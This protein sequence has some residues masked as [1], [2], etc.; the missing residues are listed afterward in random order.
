VAKSNRRRKR[1]RAVRQAKAA[2]KQA[3]ARRQQETD[4]AVQE[5]ERRAYTIRD[6]ATPAEEVAN[7]L[8]TRYEDR[9]PVMA[10]LTDGLAE[11]G[12]SPER[13][14]KISEL[15]QA[16][17]AT[18][19]KPPSMAW[20][21]F[22][23]GAA[24]AAGDTDRARRLLDQA[25]DQADDPVSRIR[26]SA[27]LRVHGRAAEAV[28]LLEGIMRE[29]PEAEFAAEQYAVTIEEI[30]ER[31]SADNPP[32]PCPCGSGESGPDCCGSRERAALDRFN[33]RSGLTAFQDAIAAYAPRSAYRKGFQEFVAEW[34]SAT[35]EDNWYSLERA[36]FTAL[37]SELALILA[38]GPDEDPGS[39]P[40]TG[41]DIGDGDGEENVLTA[42]ARDPDVPEELAGQARSWNEHIR[43]G[44]WQIAEPKA[45]PGVWCTEIATGVTRYVAFP[46][47]TI[48]RFPRW[49]VLF[50][51]IVPVD[52]IWRYTGQAFQVSPDEADALADTLTDNTEALLSDLTGQ[53]SKRATRRARRS[54]PFGR[55]KPNGVTVYAA[56]EAL[57]ETA[58]FFGM[59][60][61]SMLLGLVAEVHEH[62]AQPP[63]MANTDGDPI[64]LITAL[65][66]V[67]D[68]EGLPGL[69]ADHADFDQDPTEPTRLTWLGRIMPVNQ[70]DTLLAEVKARVGSGEPG[71]GESLSEVGPER[72]VRG[73][74]QVK[75]GA[76]VAEVNS[77]ERLTRLVDLLRKLGEDPVVTEQIR[78]DPGQDLAWP[79]GPRAFPRGAAPPEEGW[80][81]HWLDEHVPA[82]HG[83]TPRQ[84][85]QSQ[86]RVYL[87]ALLREFEYEADIL[88]AEGKAGIDTAWLR[89]EL[90]MTGDQYEWFM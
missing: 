26:L 41:S 52:G 22:A 90:D 85:A 7:L 88:A 40:G 8:A 72:W 25:F 84:A 38:E 65:I 83:Q 73:L 5:A 4:L 24:R 10:T 29:D 56:E 75:N 82:L 32:D 33:D 3:A 77:E 81:K 20:L 59:V 19:D 57:P 67:R 36:S 35:E 14:V 54:I 64:Q 11:A 74:L 16:V 55:A 9:E 50:G 61:V 68:P 48:R 1:D 39:D 69:L 43:Y 87:E 37:A 63:V 18:E 17:E 78:R 80:E 23:A 30:F 42:F 46:A 60:T 71:E 13:L 86:E 27:H 58:R 49:G 44:L 62:R 31:Q 2:R 89:H 47:G 21:T 66:A 15:W 34:R 6:P 12:S 79:A 28:E 70:R 53:P 76:L 51:G 45:A